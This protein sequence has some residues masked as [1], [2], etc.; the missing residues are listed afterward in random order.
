MSSDNDLSRQPDTFQE[1]SF[2]LWVAMLFIPIEILLVFIIL[3][4]F[5]IIPFYDWPQ[6]WTGISYF[7]LLMAV[8]FVALLFIPH[9]KGTFKQIPFSLWV[10]LLSIPAE[11][12]LSFIGFSFIYLLFPSN[13]T[14]MWNGGLIYPFT[15]MWLVSIAAVLVNLRALRILSSHK[16]LRFRLVIA[17]HYGTIILP[18]LYFHYITWFTWYIINGGRF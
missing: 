9:Q 12:L 7:S 1:I 10:P 18:N 17:I 8:V 5:K 11:A 3:S 2:P 4:L 14:S 15:W 16:S 6:I 13:V